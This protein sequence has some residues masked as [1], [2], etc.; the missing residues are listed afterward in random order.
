MSIGL[1]EALSSL[2]PGAAWTC[3]SQYE[4]IIWYDT[5]QSKPTAEEVST[6]IIR[7][8]AEYDANEYQRLREKDYPSWESQMDVLFHNGLDGWKELIQTIKDKYPKPE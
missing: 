8:Q 4:S 6:E 2:R 1:P 5:I 7:L 3:V